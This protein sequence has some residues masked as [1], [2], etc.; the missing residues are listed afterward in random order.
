M[1]MDA[2]NDEPQTETGA[3]SQENSRDTLRTKLRDLKPEKDPMGGGISQE[4]SAQN[5]T[6]EGSA[7]AS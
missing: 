2:E 3:Q 4:P 7:L 5:S 1:K 6:R